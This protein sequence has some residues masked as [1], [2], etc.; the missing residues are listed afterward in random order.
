MIEI[1]YGHK[2]NGAVLTQKKLTI[3]NGTGTYGQ[4][5]FIS[6]IEEE[7]SRCS[8]SI[9][10]ATYKFGYLRVIYRIRKYLGGFKK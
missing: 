10:Y 9:E 1:V 4:I 5:D 8:G 3:G 2:I 6:L 7:I